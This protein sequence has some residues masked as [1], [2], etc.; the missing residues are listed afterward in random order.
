MYMIPDRKVAVN[1][2]M[3]DLDHVSVYHL[4]RGKVRTVMHFNAGVNTDG[5]PVHIDIELPPKLTQVLACA[6]MGAVAKHIRYGS[7]DDDQHLEI[8]TRK[9][10]EALETEH[11]KFRLGYSDI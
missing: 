1:F 3:E 11:G 8:G 2:K 7:L 5:N 6:L 10:V 9:A 4:T